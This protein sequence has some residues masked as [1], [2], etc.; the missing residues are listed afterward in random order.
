[1][2]TFAWPLAFLLLPLFW[3]VYKYFP[4]PQKHQDAMLRV[5]FIARIQA[6]NSASGVTM[7]LPRHARQFLAIGAWILLVVASANPEWLGNPL[8][9]KQNGRNIMLA[10]DLSPSM[11]IPDLQH[12]NSTVNRLQTVK[13]VADEFIDKRLGDKLGLI[14]F[15]SKA[16]LQTPLTFDRA[17][18]HSMLDDAT[19]GLA[20]QRTAIGEAI[21][22]AI[23][24]IST[25]DIKSRILILLTDGG[26]NS[27][28]IDPLEAAQVAKDNH[29]KIYTV[30]IG[31]SQMVISSILGNQLVNPSADLDEDLLK[32]IANMTEGQYFRA[33]DE[34]SLTDILDAIN[35]LEP[36]STENKTARPITSLFYWPLA[37]ALLLFSLLVYPG[38]G[39]RMQS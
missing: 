12:N 32:K 28:T 20:G 1:M 15:G 23:K 10:V 13:A 31:A 27:G 2:F 7:K 18:V 39:R 30:G 21:G 6:L 36:I 38:L 5:P 26:N 25:E 19:I 4:K 37:A 9:V 14:L 33:Q 24:K 22:L 11:G 3:V 35:Q 16:Y 29:I 8:P 34:K 17:T